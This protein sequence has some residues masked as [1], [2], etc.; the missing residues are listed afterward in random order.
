MVELDNYFNGVSQEEKV[1]NNVDELPK[2]I[3]Q[4]WQGVPQSGAFSAMSRYGDRFI[5]LDLFADNIY[6]DNAAKWRTN[7]YNGRPYVYCMLHNFGGRSGLHGRLETTMNG[8]FEALAKGNNMQGVG[9]TP[10]V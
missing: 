8:Y 7:Y 5:G 9:A 1:A 10:R 3:I 4:Y 6:A 2:W